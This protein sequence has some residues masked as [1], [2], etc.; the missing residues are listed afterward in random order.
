MTWAGWRRL[1]R[2]TWQWVMGAPGRLT[3]WLV[4][5]EQRPHD[6]VD[7]GTAGVPCMVCLRCGEPYPCGRLV[8]MIEREDAK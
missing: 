1:F 3:A 2:E 8:T 5:V 4:E 7:V 6:P